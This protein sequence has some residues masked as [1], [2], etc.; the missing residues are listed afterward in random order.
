M[1]YL[2]KFES[3][4]GAAEP[5]QITTSEWS[6][7]LKSLGKEF[8]S[9]SEMETLVNLMENSGRDHMSKEEWD[10]LGMSEKIDNYRIGLTYLTFYLPTYDGSNPTPFEV[11]IQKCKD[12][13]FLV[14][15]YQ[16]EIDFDEGYFE[17]YEEYYECDGFECLLDLIK[18]E[19]KLG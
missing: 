12:E 10:E 1:K 4:F 9:K 17:G 18:R 6:R 19:A 15:F 16:D 7:F 13:W 14:S 5:K 3:I 11:F 2:K 8:F